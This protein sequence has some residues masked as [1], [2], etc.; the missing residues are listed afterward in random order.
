MKK[1]K[2]YKINLKKVKTSCLNYYTATHKDYFEKYSDELE[3]KPYD[4][5]FLIRFIA[6][7]ENNSSILDIG[8]CSTAQQ[9]RFFRDKGFKVTSIDLSEKCIDTA[10]N[11]FPGI[12]FIQMDM[13][14]MKFLADSFG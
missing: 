10:K 6:L 9:A 2:K 14:E 4:N 12:N 13:L 5:D 1:D 11:N 7:L 3:K 8:C